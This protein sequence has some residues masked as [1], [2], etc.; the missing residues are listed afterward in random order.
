MV[1]YRT[2]PETRIGHIH[3]KVADIDRSISFYRDVLGF[4]LNFNL[5][6]FAFLSAGGYHHQIGLNTWQS[7]GAP[8]APQRTAGLYHFAINY[9]SRRDLARAFQRLMN[10]QYPIDGAA[11]HTSHLAIYMSDPDGNGIELAWDRDPS[12]WEGWRHDLTAADAQALNKPLD[13]GAL[14]LEAEEEQS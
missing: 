9:P 12:F 8:P 3:L 4:N 13:L 10:K 5:G 11:D 1:E 7:K 6:S 14:L 2:P